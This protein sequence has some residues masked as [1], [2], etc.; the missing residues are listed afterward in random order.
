[1]KTRI[2]EILFEKIKD[3]QGEYKNFDCGNASINSHLQTNAYYDD[4][5]KYRS[6]HII[7]GKNTAGERYVLG[8]F[9]LSLIIVDYESVDD[10]K[11]DSTEYSAV[12]LEYIGVDRKYQGNGIGTSV[13][14]YVS[15]YT[16]ELSESL[17]CRFFILDA[18]VEVV[19]W[20]AERGFLYLDD[21]TKTDKISPTRR[22]YL[23]YK[24]MRK[25]DLYAMC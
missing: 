15:G 2:I 8:F 7:R 6:T 20:Y 21:E 18:L 10:G 17:G 16:Q 23:D 13:I 4:I 1:M 25:V 5:M 11:L 9:T 12:Y 24:D 14:E 19:N 3:N 22:V